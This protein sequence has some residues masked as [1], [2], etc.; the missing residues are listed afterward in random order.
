MLLTAGP[1]HPTATVLRDFKSGYKSCAGEHAYW[2]EDDEIEGTIPPE[3]EGTLFRNGPGLLDIG[4]KALNQPFDG[5]GMLVRLAFKDGRCSSL[6]TTGHRPI[7]DH[8][9]IFSRD[10]NHSHSS[11]R[12]LELTCRRRSATLAEFCAEPRFHIP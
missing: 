11:S 2:F 10:P 9:S 3:L 12:L 7:F 1:I 8:S 4:G 5:D 6:S